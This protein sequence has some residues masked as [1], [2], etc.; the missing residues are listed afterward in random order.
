MALLPASVIACCI[1][2]SEAMIV[3]AI[4]GERNW[5]ASWW[6]WHGLV[7]AAFLVILFAAQ[8]EWKDE[9]FRRLYL[10]TTRERAQDVSVLFGDLEGYT[11][12]AERVG[13]HEVAEMLDTYYT[14]ATPLISRRFGGVVEKFMG[15]GIMATFNRGGDQ[16]DHA[17]QAARAALELQHQLTEISDMHPGWPRIRIGVNTGEAVV[18]ELGGQGHVEYAVVGDTI[19]TGSRLE[20]KAPV[21]MVLI[22]AET[23]RRLPAG[24]VVEAMPGLVVKG[25]QDPVDAYLLRTLP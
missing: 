9:R 20:G 16:P 1:L 8:R 7:V 6:E 21:G 24:T 5:H 4:T 22:G 25:K 3:V 19:N 10:T 11:S 23:Y 18:R 13:P 15:D 12:F 14:V 2:L 17:V